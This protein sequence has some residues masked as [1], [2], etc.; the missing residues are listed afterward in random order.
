MQ[1]S[2]TDKSQP[3]NFGSRYNSAHREWKFR[4]KK[5]DS[6][7]E[8]FIRDTIP[9]FWDTTYSEDPRE[10]YGG[11]KQIYTLKE[12]NCD[13]KWFDGNQSDIALGRGDLDEGDNI[14][15]DELPHLS[16][17]DG[18]SKYIQSRF[19]GV[20]NFRK[21]RSNLVQ[22]MY[23]SSRE[24]LGPNFLWSSREQPNNNNRI[25]NSFLNANVPGP[26]LTTPLTS[27]MPRSELLSSPL[28]PTSPQRCRSGDP[29]REA[30][31]STDESADNIYL[32][33]NNYIGT[34]NPS[35]LPKCS[36]A[37][38]CRCRPSS[39]EGSDPSKCY[40][41]TG[42]CGVDQGLQECNRDDLETT[43][44]NKTYKKWS[45]KDKD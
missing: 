41:D 20:N 36:Q 12:S 16:M 11:A 35:T 44:T 31:W 27:T 25:F 32:D 14:I 38:K 22:S 7:G 17:M 2:N 33:N 39:H 45:V 19:S 24:A 42:H 23:P 1:S 5:S 10:G 37:T 21:V 8:N 28:G 26:I 13:N 18:P 43:R 15:V 30:D 3:G 40:V 34:E 4:L 6:L 29:T 9:A